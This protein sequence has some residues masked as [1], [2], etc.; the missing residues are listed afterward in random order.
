MT[1]A[2]PVIA[3]FYGSLLAAL[4]IFLSLRVIRMRR[5]NKVALGDAKH[6]SLQ[7]AIRAHGN[8]AE[9]VPLALLLAA[10]VEFQQFSSLIV[11]LICLAL[12]LGRVV[13]AYGVSQEDENYR[14]RVTGMALTIAAIAASALLLSASFV[15]GI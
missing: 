5:K 3:P 9:Y 15:F 8:F 4:Y 13:H 6:P 2:I 11:H 12:I 1:A 7:R 14:F 10:F